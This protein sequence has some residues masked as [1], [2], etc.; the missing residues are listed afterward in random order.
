MRKSMR[1][2]DDQVANPRADRTRAQEAKSWVAA[3]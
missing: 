2:E 3:V 1:Q